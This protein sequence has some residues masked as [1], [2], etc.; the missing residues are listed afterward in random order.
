MISKKAKILLLY[1]SFEKYV[2]A[3]LN[4]KT[5]LDQFVCQTMGDEI[6][7]LVSDD[8]VD[9]EWEDEENEEYFLEH[10]LSRKNCKFLV[11]EEV[12]KK[13]YGSAVEEIVDTLNKKYFSNSILLR[14]AI[15]KVVLESV[16]SMY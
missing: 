1:G 14:P 16:K 5:Y 15:K 8:E 11:W 7:C 10:G 12:Y 2:E 6:L 4:E 13:Y 9:E 3:I